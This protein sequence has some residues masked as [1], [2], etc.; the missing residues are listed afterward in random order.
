MSVQNLQTC[1]TITKF[2]NCLKTVQYSDTL[3]GQCS[4]WELK[5]YSSNTYYAPS[6][7]TRSAR[8][9]SVASRSTTLVSL[10]HTHTHTERTHHTSLSGRQ[11]RDSSHWHDKRQ[12]PE[13]SGD[14]KR[15]WIP[16][17]L[18][19]HN[20]CRAHD[21]RCFMASWNYGQ[22]SL[23]LQKR[24]LDSTWRIQRQVETR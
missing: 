10:S 6:M 16:I 21:Q 7:C 11:P 5:H 22:L 13:T 12:Q 20:D 19:L 9:F 2:R 18:T 1:R 17:V 8:P 4:Y 24:F 23:T 3:S 15:L 14:Q